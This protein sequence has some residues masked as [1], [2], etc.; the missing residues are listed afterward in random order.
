MATAP[1]INP[2]VLNLYQ[3]IQRLKLDVGSVVPLHGSVSYR[4]PM[5]SP[6]RADCKELDW[7]HLQVAQPCPERADSESKGAG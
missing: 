1:P 5:S 2:V 3:N 4:S 6:P 7:G